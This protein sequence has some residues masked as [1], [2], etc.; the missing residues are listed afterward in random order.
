MKA[1]DP[2]RD[3]KSLVMRTY[4]QIAEEFN[5]MRAV[6]VADERAPLLAVLRARR[7]HPRPRV[8]VWN[9]DL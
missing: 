3:Y 4:D 7:D 2:N 1:A 9:A 8:R 6:E 5:R